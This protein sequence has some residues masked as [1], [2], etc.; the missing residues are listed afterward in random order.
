MQIPP[1]AASQR[2]CFRYELALE[3]RSTK[4][5]VD[6]ALRRVQIV[7]LRHGVYISA[8]ALAAVRPEDRHLLDLQADQLALG[9][10]WYAARRSA[11]VV[12]G[13]PLIGA[14]P[15][16]PQLLADP[17]E[18]RS[19]A[20]NRHRRFAPLPQ[21]DR[22]TV[23]GLNVVS[24]ARLVADIA[25]SEPFRNAVVVA[26][27][28]LGQ[29]V[30]KAELVRCLT[31]MKRWPGVIGARRAVEFAD[32]LSETVLE[33]ISRVAIQELELPPPELQ[34][35]VWLDRQLLGRVDKL[36]RQ[37]N[38]VGE[39]DGLRKYGDDDASRKKAFGKEKVRQ[40]WLEDIGLEVARWT[41][42]EA[43]R[44][45]GVLDARLERA[46]SRGSQQQ[47]DP[48]VR[49]VPTTVADRLRREESF[50]RAG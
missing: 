49:F 2:G 33:S 20:R 46:F 29:G 42:A 5:D 22:R 25:R 43:W 21:C 50:R 36:W 10:A 31:Q 35:E 12:L 45:R 4:A 48:R 30:D 19:S 26:D 3:S 28:V 40:E 37:F 15:T 9:S 11:A 18:A 17:G 8:E 27:A 7:K 13:I 14:A 47:L 39:D 16:V 38:T 23:E 6:T 32:G 1:I 24:H 44:P 41:W 34:V